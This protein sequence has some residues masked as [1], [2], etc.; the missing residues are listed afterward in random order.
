MILFASCI[1]MAQNT[2]YANWGNIK[3][4]ENTSN[5]SQPKTQTNYSYKVVVKLDDHAKAGSDSGGK[6]M[7][8]GTHG[9]ATKDLGNSGINDWQIG[10]ES[11]FFINASKNIGDLEQIV[12]Q[13]KKKSGESWID[14]IKLE[15]ISVT[16][17]AT[18]KTTGKVSCKCWIGDGSKDNPI[19]RKAK[20][21][22]ITSW[23]TPEE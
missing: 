18:G 12:I 8:S 23:D 16:E 3:P 9:N 10:Q 17:V 22:T 2:Q 14:D 21:L 5:S 19:E 11:P 1:T 6:I 7:L 4:V 13:M 15:W 20:T